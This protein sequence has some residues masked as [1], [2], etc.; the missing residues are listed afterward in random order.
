VA[1]IQLAL[2]G[3]DGELSPTIILSDEPE[4][5]VHRTGEEQVVTGMLALTDGPR[6]AGIVATHSPAFFDCSEIRLLHVRRNLRGRT[7][8]SV[9]D[10]L[11]HDVDLGFT[12]ADLLARRRVFVVVEGEHDR[13]VLQTL[14]RR[15]LERA[16][17]QVLVLRGASR[18]ITAAHAEWLLDASDAPL[19]IVF[20]KLRE[21]R[22]RD[23]WAAVPDLLRQGRIDDALQMVWG[24]KEIGKDEAGWLARLG[25]EAIR[26]GT[27]RR[28]RF[29][30]LGA[31]DILMYLPDGPRLVADKRAG[32]LAT[33]TVQ[34][35]ASSLDEIPSDLTDLMN[36]I[37]ELAASF[38][39]GSSASL[40]H[41]GSRMGGIAS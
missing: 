4:A 3:G 7:E 30:G 9:L 19:L 36:A 17:A 16:F 5:G 14:F 37:L 23:T 25:E 35:I 41:A 6:R 39:R 20:D 10:G 34:S 12:K 27:F 8:V 33:T 1:A 28:L 26:T 40:T 31:D 21:S 29:H 22:V 24:L 38:G 18:G 11:P 13:I 2:G 15:E 32:T